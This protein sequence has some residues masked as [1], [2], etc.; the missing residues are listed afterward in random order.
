MCESRRDSPTCCSA[1]STNS[2]VFL[3]P[4]P[5]P[6]TLKAEE[7]AY[8]YA[9]ATKFGDGIGDR[10]RARHRLDRAEATGVPVGG[11]LPLVGIGLSN[12][13]ERLGIRFIRRLPRW[14]ARQRHDARQWRTPHFDVALL[15]SGAGFSALT[16]QAYNG[17]N[18]DGPYSG[19][20]DGFDG[21]ES[22][23]PSPAPPVVSPPTSTSRSACT[24]LVYRT[25]PARRPSP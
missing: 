6:P 13:Y 2:A 24:R 14:P 4:V 3:T 17:F 11:F 23:S 16:A 18:I 9:P 12:E 5:L 25:A 7:E 19:N 15:D 10:L 8:E 20:S 1:C 22:S 21:T